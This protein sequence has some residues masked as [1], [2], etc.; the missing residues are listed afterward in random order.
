M[1]SAATAGTAA[2]GTPG[3][4][5][6]P[7]ADAPVVTGIG[8]VS[9][10]GIGHEAHWAA[11][12][13]ADPAIG[14]LR[15][16]DASSYPTRLGGEVPGFDT[17]D[18][19]PGRLIPQTDHWTHLALAATDLALADAGVVPEDL[20][21]YEMAVVTAGSSGGVE[22]G[23]REIQALWGKGPRHVGAYQSIAW[24][25]AATTGQISIR[26][27]MRGPCGVVVA[28]QAGALESFAQARR[29]LADGTRMVV[30][31]GTD[32]PF[33]PYGLTCQLSSG[34]LSTR[35]DPARAYLPFD[36]AAAGYVPGEGG[37]ILIVESAASARARGAGPGYGRI[38][39]YA[40]TFDPPPGS[41]R[42]PTLA[43]AIRTALAEAALDAADVDVVFADAAGVPALDEAEARALA[44]VFG[45]R[46]VP[47]TAPKS[48]TGRLYAGG[49]ALDVATALLAM[50]DSAIPP[51]AGVTDVPDGYAL[52]LVRGD[53]VPA[54]LRGVLVL[55]RGYGGFN[56]A[57]VLRGTD[58][59]PTGDPTTSDH[60]TSDHTTSETTSD[61]TTQG[62]QP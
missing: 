47:V 16:F 11:T 60:K 21:E 57:L 27:G 18:R 13:R 7:L 29:H 31:G 40:A 54:A 4:T 23:Q 25:Y 15:R 30:A 58:D 46:G 12:L 41:G 3:G 10:T 44:E 17:A 33:S 24:F 51:T 20:P 19:V 34:R 61:H 14:P 37:A 59:A 50:R 8:V 22:F 9:P 32:A 28:E 2:A 1:S 43:R 55:A 35:T 42:P 52:D 39:G 62:S 53:P 38:A 6:D 56:A 5:A 48:M 26:H 49:A 36:A 45:P